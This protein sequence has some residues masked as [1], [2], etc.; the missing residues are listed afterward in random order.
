[1][2]IIGALLALLFRNALVG[3]TP[4]FGAVSAALNAG[5]TAKE[6]REYESLTDNEYWNGLYL[7]QNDKYM[8]F[9]G[10]T[11]IFSSLVQHSENA[12]EMKL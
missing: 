8:A 1:M 5:S 4:G 11:F 3:P 2:C 12:M 6:S 9:R 10:K 7:K